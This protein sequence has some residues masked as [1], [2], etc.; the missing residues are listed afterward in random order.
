MNFQL[1]LFDTF[2]ANFSFFVFFF[3]TNDLNKRTKQKISLEKI[4]REGIIID[5]YDQTET[6]LIHIVLNISTL[7]IDQPNIYIYINIY[8]II[9][10]KRK[11][12]E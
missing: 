6:F 3:P 11:K 9:F 10:G 7:V 5:F 2:Y 8:I 4:G 1:L 12:K